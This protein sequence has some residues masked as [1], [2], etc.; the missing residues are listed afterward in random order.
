[1]PRSRPFR[2][3]FIPTANGGVNYYRM[4]AWA[5]EMRSYRNVEAAVFAFQYGLNEIHPWQ[6]DLISV[7]EVREHIESLVRV[8]DAVVWQ[9]VHYDNTLD[10]FN[11]LRQKYGK[12]TL[13]ETDDNFIDVP[14]WN[15]A[16]MSFNPNSRHRYTCLQSMEMAD[17]LIVTTP[18]LK[19]LY[20]AYN[21]DVVIMPNSLDFVG[22]RKFIGWD[23]VSVR[24]HRGVR[25]GWIGGRSHFSDLM[26]V[27]P[28]IRE[29]LEKYPDVTF[30]MVN[31]AMKESC[32]ALGIK[33]P[34]E[35]LSNA[36][37]AD[38]SVPI[39]RYAQFMAH[40]GFDI[41][42]APLVDC[43]FNRSKS[44]LRWLEYSALKIPCVASMISH[45]TQTVHDGEDGFLVPN[46]DPQVWMNRLE[47]LINDVA[48][49]EGMGRAAYARVKQDFNIRRNAPAYVRHLKKISDFS[50]LDPE[51]Q[52]VA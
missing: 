47:R 11:D 51:Y 27:A 33:Y 25:I 24:K 52:E 21:S 34:F 39:N 12:T 40:F 4:A 37:E 29:I 13:V 6:R 17:G 46:N 48:L 16:Y 23:K 26:L 10:F 19:E 41:G 18:H 14:P 22:D 50:V 3:A 8:A 7:P 9:P 35:G 36:K 49:R 15:N 38:R 5:F 44:N 30:C 1:M 20:G 32:K 31:S 45:F 42:I 43:N 28:V 2:V